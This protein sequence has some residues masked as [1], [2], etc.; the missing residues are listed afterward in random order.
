MNPTGHALKFQN[1]G[2]IPE[3]AEVRVY[4]I[5]ELGEYWYGWQILLPEDW[6]PALR[7]D[8]GGGADI[9]TQWH[10]GGANLPRWSRGHPMTINISDEGNYRITWNY[11]G[12]ERIKC[13]SIL[14]GIN[15]FDDRGKWINWAFHV[16]WAKEDTPGG[17]FMRLYHDGDLVFSNEGPNHENIRT[18]MMWKAGIYHGNP[19]LLPTN[20]Y[21]IYADNFIL[22][23]PEGNLSVVNPY[24]S[25]DE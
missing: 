6:Q 3:R 8:Q 7:S 13:D 14:S 5:N 1:G 20:P 19:S 18:W 9:I 16:K 22:M 12:P 25:S 11:G 17:G 23:G 10:R 2:S 15:A 4:G 21:I 24:L